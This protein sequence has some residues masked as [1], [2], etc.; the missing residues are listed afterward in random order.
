MPEARRRP[1]AAA[2]TEAKS[3]FLAR[4]SHELRTPL[5]G[6]VGLAQVLAR[7]PAL[8][9]VQRTQAE[10]LEAAGRHL[11]AVANDVLDLDVWRDLGTGGAGQ[12]RG[13]L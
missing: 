9:G 12:G 13:P 3:R 5:N 10:T 2:A 1:A 8:S 11:V 4:M 6:V 7:D